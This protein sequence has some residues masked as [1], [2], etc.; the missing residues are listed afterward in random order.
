M[1]PS[2]PPMRRE[3]PEK[4]EFIEQL[5]LPVVNIVFLLVPV[6]LV[7]IEVTSFA[8][9]QATMPDAP[10]AARAPAVTS[11]REA[12]PPPQPSQTSTAG[13]ESP[14]PAPLFPDQMLGYGF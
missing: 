5:L 7:V 12:A 8:A 2:W 10:Q 13:A 14:N 11:P 4:A 1:R 9:L 3:R 6:L